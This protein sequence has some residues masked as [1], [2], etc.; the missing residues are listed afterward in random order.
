MK[1]HYPIKGINLNII[2]MKKNL[3]RENEENMERTNNKEKKNNNIITRNNLLKNLKPNITINETSTEKDK[4]NIKYKTE[5]CKPNLIIKKIIINQNMNDN[6]YINKAIDLYNI[7]LNDNSND[8]KYSRKNNILKLKNSNNENIMMDE[9]TNIRRNISS[10]KINYKLKNNN[11]FFYINNNNRTLNIIKE[12]TSNFAYKKKIRNSSSFKPRKYENKIKF[13]FE[14]YLESLLDKN[15]QKKSLESNIKNYMCN[16]LKNSTYRSQRNSKNKTCYTQNNKIFNSFDNDKIIK[17]RNNNMNRIYNKI[18]NKSFAKTSMIKRR[19]LNWPIQSDNDSDNNGKNDNE[20]NNYT[21]KTMYNYNEYKDKN[22]IYLNNS[23]DNEINNDGKSLRLLTKNKNK[24]IKTLNPLNTIYKNNKNVTIPENYFYN[25]SRTIA[26]IFNNKNKSPSLFHKK[27]S[28][29]INKMNITK[30]NINKIYQKK[31]IINKNRE[32]S[33]KT[34]DFIKVKSLVFNLNN[35]MDKITKNE[36]NINNIDINSSLVYENI[37]EK[38]VNQFYCFQKKK[39]N[40]FIKNPIKKEYYLDKVKFYKKNKDKLNISDI[41]NKTLRLNNISKNYPNFD[42]S[43]IDGKKNSN[44]NNKLTS[45][46]N[47]SLGIKILKEIL[48]KKNGQVR[49]TMAEKQFYLGNNNLNERNEHTYTFRKDKEN[50]L[51]E[52]EDFEKE[53]VTERVN[54]DKIIF[55]KGKYPKLNLKINNTNKNFYYKF[56][57]IFSNDSKNKKNPKNKINNDESKKEL[58]SLE[59]KNRIELL[60]DYKEENKIK[61]KENLEFIKDIILKDFQ[62][63]IKYLEKENIKNKEDIYDS[64][65][66]SY[67]WKIIDELITKENVKIEDIIKIY[68]NICKN[69][70]FIDKNTIFKANEYIKSIIEYYTYNLSKNQKEIIHLYMIEEYNNINNILNNSNEYIFEILGNLLF[71]LLKNK[72]Y[73]MKDLNYFIDKEKNIQITIAKIVRYA[74]IASGNL[75]KQYHNDFK[76]T[77]LF[78]NNDIF[79]K[80]IT[81]EIY[82]NDN[83]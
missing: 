24:E 83:K 39:Y 80:Y 68:I 31:N 67:N 52:V 15:N 21:N 28:K 50:K 10:S 38:V 47:I 13:E 58:K 19:G 42:L 69:N 29:N 35:D 37:N 9:K 44:E 22:N 26:I 4:T 81:K 16:V 62:N 43:E 78:N 36:N 27:I 79:I 75:S 11:N 23:L 61:G 54:T 17:N 71:I 59:K 41:E 48:I 70:N 32:L 51:I 45:F 56:K 53:K 2:E 18:N 57:E 74:I 73:Y 7:K 60:N 25:N 14:N 6:K 46:Q 34:R 20:I 3:E 1:T 77:K 76:K 40:Y 8:C 12:N 49:K 30:G 55:E 63:Y 5:Y 66:D 33:T 82:G 64:M 72:L 65:N